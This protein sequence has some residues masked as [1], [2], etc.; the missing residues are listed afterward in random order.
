M[1]H[2]IEHHGEGLRRQVE[3]HAG[4]GRARI[5]R[6]QRLV[7]EL[8]RQGRSAAYLARHVLRTMLGSQKQLEAFL[9]Q[10]R[11]RS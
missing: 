2:D 6:Q 4:E 3:R 11:R 7:E 8:E 10:L 1:P 9:A 5:L